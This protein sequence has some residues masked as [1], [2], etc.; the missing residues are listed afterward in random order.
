[1]KKNLVLR[2]YRN[3]LGLTQQQ[4]SEQLN[5]SKQSYCNK[6]LGKVQF[7]DTEKQQIKSILATKYPKIT[8]DEIF[9]LH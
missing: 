9:F 7:S 5:I 6:E 8:I 2:G 4:M 1:M 3:M